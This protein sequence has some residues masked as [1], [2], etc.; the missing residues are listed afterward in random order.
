MQVAGS[1]YP[2]EM[3]AVDILGDFHSQNLAINGLGVLKI[4]QTQSVF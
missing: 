4:H 1:G 3:I 2:L